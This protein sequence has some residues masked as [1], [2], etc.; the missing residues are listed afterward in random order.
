MASP[1]I[2][3]TV[4]RDTI[5]GQMLANTCPANIVDFIDGKW[6]ACQC[7]TGAIRREGCDHYNMFGY[8]L[9]CSTSF[10]V[11]KFTNVGIVNIYYSGSVSPL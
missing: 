10:V 4:G 8:D 2:I 9:C 6:V 11:A 3:E 1:E 7:S 5:F